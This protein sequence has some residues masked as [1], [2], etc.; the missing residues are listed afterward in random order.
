MNSSFLSLISIQR[1]AGRTKKQIC[2]SGTTEKI[3]GRGTVQSPGKNFVRLVV[4]PEFGSQIG[5]SGSKF[6]IGVGLF[7]CLLIDSC[8]K[9][10]HQHKKQ[11]KNTKQKERKKGR[12]GM[13]RIFL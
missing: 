10:K 9:K 12:N 4:L 13:I 1:K 2:G 8:G 3:Q 5:D 7:Y 6:G 11:D